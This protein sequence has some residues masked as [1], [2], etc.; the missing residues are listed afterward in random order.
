MMPVLI[1][2]EL[3]MEETECFELFGAC[4]I[5]VEFDVFTSQ[6][7]RYRKHGILLVT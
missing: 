3:S 4:V 6:K 5:C 2:L 1:D 7:T